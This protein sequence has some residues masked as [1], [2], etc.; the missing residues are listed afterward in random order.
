MINRVNANKC[1]CIEIL[2]SKSKQQNNKNFN[3]IA[4]LFRHLS[5]SS[6]ETFLPVDGIDGC[7]NIRAIS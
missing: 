5:M 3:E 6:T 1:G 7:R 4:H 2:G